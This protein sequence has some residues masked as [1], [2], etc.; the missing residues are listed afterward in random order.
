MAVTEKEER[1]TGAKGK[2]ASAEDSG[3]Q[4]MY[5]NITLINKRGGSPKKK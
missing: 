3:K 1:N 5:V 4:C 2:G